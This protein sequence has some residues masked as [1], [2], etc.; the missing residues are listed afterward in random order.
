MSKQGR[1]NLKKI[2]VLFA[3]ALLFYQTGWAGTTKTAKNKTSILNKILKKFDET[4][5][6]AEKKMQSMMSGC[7]SS[8]AAALLSFIIG[9]PIIDEPCVKVTED[10]RKEIDDYFDFVARNPKNIVNSKPD[11]H[12]P[13]AS[14]ARKRLKEIVGDKFQSAL[15]KCMS[16]RFSKKHCE[17]A[18]R[19]IAS[20]LLKD[21][22]FVEELFIQAKEEEAN[23]KE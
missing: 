15:E 21:E 20:S 22:A 23:S 14:I 11:I 7:G 18:F 2:I 13:I 1:N 10:L 8:P 17:E 12:S 3:C 16:G 6:D 4:H 19:H 9:A 5:Y